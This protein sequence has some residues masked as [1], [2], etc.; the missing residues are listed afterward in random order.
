[1]LAIYGGRDSRVLGA[2]NAR[3]MET[4]LRDAG[5]RDFTVKLYP[6]GNHD[7]I[8]VDDLP[9]S[10]ALGPSRYVPGYFDDLLSWITTRA[11]GGRRPVTDDAR[12]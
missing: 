1:M 12:R 8:E 4:Y 3:L 9:V 7:M 5:N 2:E 11:F 6:T 10:D